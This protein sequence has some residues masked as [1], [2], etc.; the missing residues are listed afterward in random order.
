MEFKENC[1]T[2]STNSVN[3]KKNVKVNF[4]FFDLLNE[5]EINI[6]NNILKELE[7]YKKQLKDELKQEILEELKEENSKKDLLMNE[8]IQSMNNS[9]QQLL[10]CINKNTDK[11]DKINIMSDNFIQMFNYVLDELKI[12]RQSSE[13]NESNI[14]ESEN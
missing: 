5:S 7:E 3:I 12:L 1:L 13:S 2:K 10:K 14:N 11:I 9:V 4:S 8:T 6:K